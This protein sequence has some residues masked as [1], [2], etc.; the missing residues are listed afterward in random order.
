ME[1]VDAS[2]ELLEG[3]VG[4]SS[5]LCCISSASTL[6][7]GESLFLFILHHFSGWLLCRDVLKALVSFFFFIFLDFIPYYFFFYF[8][9]IILMDLWSAKKKKN[10]LQSVYH[11]EPD[12]SS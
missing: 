9:A 3:S 12:I 1:P 5:S 10:A 4:R 6:G 2:P 8:F 11:L 7:C